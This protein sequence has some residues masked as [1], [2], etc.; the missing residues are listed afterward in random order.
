MGSI[1]NVNLPM[2]QPV[3]ILE[4]VQNTQLIQAQEQAQLLWSMI[5]GPVL[6]YVFIYCDLTIFVEI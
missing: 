6:S 3:V 2:I 4:S 5:N 1:Q